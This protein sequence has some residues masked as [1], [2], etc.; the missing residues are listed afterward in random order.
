M[1]EPTNDSSHMSLNRVVRIVQFFAI[2]LVLLAC[3]SL[4]AAVLMGR[5]A[6]TPSKLWSR[7]NLG[8]VAWAMLQYA[9]IRK[10]LPPAVVRSA[11][12]K[13]LYS[14]RVLLLPF[15]EQENLYGKFQLNEPWDSPH[16]KALLPLM[17]R[18]YASEQTYP[19]RPDVTYIQVL[20]GK[21]TAFEPGRNLK[22]KIGR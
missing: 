17:P 9:D 2:G 13:P 16:N 10:S 5:R 22:P 18:V 4:L 7:A 8:E 14:W 12:G 6:E 21:G 15:L 20:V 3:I 1:A 19:N 11:D